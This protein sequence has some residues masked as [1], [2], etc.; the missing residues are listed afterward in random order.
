[1]FFTTN[2]IVEPTL[3]FCLKEPGKVLES[4][5][6]SSAGD[7]T[8]VWGPGLALTAFTYLLYTAHLQTAGQYLALQ[9]CNFS[10]QIVY[11]F[12]IL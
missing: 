12:I 6:K 1:M 9:V 10:C 7:T 4:R 2:F 11:N 8:P 5:V 3:I